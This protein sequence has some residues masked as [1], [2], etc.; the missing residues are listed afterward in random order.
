LGKARNGNVEV[1][2]GEEDIDELSKIVLNGRQIKNV[3]SISQ[4]VAVEKK[5]PVTLEGIRLAH[6]FSQ[7]SM[8]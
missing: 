5:A 3:M 7:M 8:D 1:A 6:G 4:A 2:V